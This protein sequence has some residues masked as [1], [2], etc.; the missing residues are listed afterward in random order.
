MKIIF[1]RHGE[2]DDF[3]NDGNHLGNPKCLL[4][5][6][7]QEEAKQ[8][9]IVIKNA[10]NPKYLISSTSPR[11][12]QTAQIINEQI[13][14]NFE[15]LEIG[16]DEEMQPN[17]VPYPLKISKETFKKAIVTLSQAYT[18]AKRIIMELLSKEFNGDVIHIT[19]DQRMIMLHWLVLYNRKPKP[20]E[21]LNFWNNYKNTELSQHQ[22]PKT[23]HCKMFAID[24]ENHKIEYPYEIYHKKAK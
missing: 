6:I 7:G 5:E 13:G 14:K 21:Y 19:H 9:G 10:Y 3:D 20:E 23:R 12:Y 24:S 22:H 16:V 4:T 1:V 11:A 2:P 18:E 15:I 17:T 8:A